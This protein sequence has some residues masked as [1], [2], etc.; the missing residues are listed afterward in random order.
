VLMSK[1]KVLIK[2]LCWSVGMV[3]DPRRLLG[4]STTGPEVDGGVTPFLPLFS[5]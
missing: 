2:D 1:D 3:Y 4:V 5:P